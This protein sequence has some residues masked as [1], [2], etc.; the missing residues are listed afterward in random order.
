MSGRGRKDRDERSKVGSSGACCWSGLCVRYCTRK[1][2]PAQVL[3]AAAQLQRYG[4]F[5]S[6]PTARAGSQLIARDLRSTGARRAGAVRVLCGCCAV[7]GGCGGLGC[8]RLLALP[9]SHQD[10]QCAHTWATR[11]CARARLVGPL[12]WEQREEIGC[13][14]ASLYAAGLARS[15]TGGGRYSESRRRA[16]SGNSAVVLWR[17]ADAVPSESPDAKVRSVAQAV[18][19]GRSDAS[20][21]V[22]R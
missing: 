17:L 12:P 21:W 8:W 6:G 20:R 2:R 4:G 11:A 7:G 13:E 14:S 16:V 9:G 1:A 10:V 15:T 22:T 3:A 19:G 18:T 5:G